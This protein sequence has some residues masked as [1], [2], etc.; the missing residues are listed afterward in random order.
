[1]IDILNWFNTSANGHPYM[2]LLHCSWNDVVV[3]TLLVLLRF[4][5]V[6]QYGDIAI[7]DFVNYKKYPSS[8]LSR[9]FLEKTKVF[10]F[11]LLAGYG[12]GLLS[13]I[14]NPYKLL[15]VLLVILNYVTYKFR[16][17]FK[18]LDVFYKIHQLEE[19]FS[20]TIKEIEKIQKSIVLNLFKGSGIVKMINFETLDKIEYNKPFDSD[21][22]GVIINTR[23]N[24]EIPGFTSTS[25][26]KANSYVKKHQ[27]DTDKILKCIK[28][29][30]Y[31]SN[32]QKWYNEGEHL[33]I[34]KATI[35]NHLE[36]WHDIRTS[37]EETELL[38][39]IM[40]E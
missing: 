5:I 24:E 2:S 15:I 30:F 14:Y 20:P 33:F 23:I 36:N 19:R 18:N 21:G 32:T 31:D 11:C 37:D 1:M 28:G 22:N 8:R 38:T 17:S 35:E 40:P 13:T 16:T 10:I 26:M 12:Y 7:K 9:Y 6:Y 27:H 34:P 29:K 25:V 4:G 39:F 3:V